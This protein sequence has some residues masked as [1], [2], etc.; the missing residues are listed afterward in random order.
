MAAKRTD[1]RTD[2]DNDDDSDDINNKP[3]SPAPPASNEKGYRYKGY[4]DS[5]KIN[6]GKEP[7]KKDR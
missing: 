2:D 4:S 1:N 5:T 6:N 7:A 3:T